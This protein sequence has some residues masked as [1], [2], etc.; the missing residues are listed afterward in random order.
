MR[1]G[2]FINQTLIVSSNKSIP[3]L[4]HFSVLVDLAPNFEKPGE[5]FGP[6][7]RANA[8]MIQISIQSS[9][10]GENI[11]YTVNFV[12]PCLMFSSNEN[13]EKAK[14]HV[15]KGRGVN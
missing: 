8:P 10:V 9:D 6:W 11:S 15:I 3:S 13:E 14:N 2:T 5:N 7:A 4:T 1:S 12:H